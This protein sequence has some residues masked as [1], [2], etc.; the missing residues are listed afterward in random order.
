M[1]AGAGPTVKA[2][3]VLIVAQGTLRLVTSSTPCVP[4][5]A[6]SPRKALFLSAQGFPARVVNGPYEMRPPCMYMYSSPTA[7]VATPKK[8]KP[9][10]YGC[11]CGTGKLLRVRRR[12]G[13]WS[14][15]GGKSEPGETPLATATRELEEETGYGSKKPPGTG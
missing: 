7:R 3:T 2:A 6:R 13:G 14:E 12:K 5:C 9:Y 8:K 15:P 10:V 1:G 11:T 4:G